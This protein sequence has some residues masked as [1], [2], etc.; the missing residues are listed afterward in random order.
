MMIEFI[1]RMLS[2]YDLQVVNK[3]AYDSLLN[4]SAECRFDKWYEKF[5]KDDI[6]NVWFETREEY[7][8][9]WDKF[10][11]AMGNDAK[12]NGYLQGKGFVMDEVIVDKTVNKFKRQIIVK[13]S[14]YGKLVKLANAF[15][16]EV[17]SN[18][19]RK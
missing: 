2:R 1:N 18:D 3:S 10:R 5:D 17:D 9:K 12:V 4:G 14:N 7:D 11:L 15:K 13:E 16:V 6:Y 8:E 19:D